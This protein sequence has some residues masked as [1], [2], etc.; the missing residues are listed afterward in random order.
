MKLNRSL[1]VVAACGF[2]AASASARLGETEAQSLARYGVPAPEL[3][4]PQDKPLIEGAK[5]SIFN[6]QGWR[7]RVAFLNNVA[8]RLEY[9]HLAEN[10]VLKP[11]TCRLR[12]G[13]NNALR[14]TDGGGACFAQSHLYTLAPIRLSG[15]ARGIDSALFSSW[16][17]SV[18]ASF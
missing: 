14:G 6:F 7:V 18:P 1:L 5:E 17:E 16:P 2:I 4:G 13:K 9:V 3:A 8:A 15:A 10:G 12:S 11:I